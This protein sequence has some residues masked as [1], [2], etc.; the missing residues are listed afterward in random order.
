[1]VESWRYW[2]PHLRYTTVW[3]N[4]SG[5]TGGWALEDIPCLLPEAFWLSPKAPG[6]AYVNIFDEDTFITAAGLLSS[7]PEVQEAARDAVECLRREL[8]RPAVVVLAKVAEGAW[9]E[10]GLTLAAHLDG[11]AGRRL[12]SRLA[13]QSLSWPGLV[14][15]VRNAMNTPDVVAALRS[16]ELSPN[17]FDHV[18]VWTNVL[19]DA[20]NAIHF[21]AGASV[22]NTAE[23]VTTIFIDGV[24]C[25]RKLYLARWA[26][27]G[28]RRAEGG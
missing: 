14:K 17:A 16:V 24:D 4:S 13:D 7:A 21:G 8:H 25:I 6:G 19:R 3:R 9:V 26:L 20:R 11:S 12:L 5:S 18:E 28:Q 1:M 27:T 10:L 22:P 15:A 2:Y 23:K